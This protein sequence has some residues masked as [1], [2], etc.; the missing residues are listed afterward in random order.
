MSLDHYIFFIMG[1]VIGWFSIFIGTPIKEVKGIWIKIL[2][3]L[4]ISL[5]FTALWYLTIKLKVN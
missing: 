2:W 1:L 3:L 4:F 5:S